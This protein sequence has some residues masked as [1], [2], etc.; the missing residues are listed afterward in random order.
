MRRV[1]AGA[2]EGDPKNVL[3]PLVLAPKPAPKLKLEQFAALEK[4]GQISLT[5]EAQRALKN[6]ADGWIAHDRALHSPR[7]AEFRARLC[8]MIASLEK[9]YAETDLLRA[10]APVLDQHLYHWLMGKDGTSDV[11]GQL[12]ALPTTIEFLRKAKSSLAADSGSARPMDEGRFI[13][14]LADQFE[15]CGCKARAYATSHKADGYAHTPFRAFVHIFYG[16]L[17]LKSRRTRSGLDE[18]MCRA[19]RDRRTGRT[20]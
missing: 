20:R 6:I 16:F 13:Q 7:P 12:A 17:S 18:A 14:F 2:R 15:K 10:D 8:S 4:S 1:K 11:L 9:A 5:T 19:L 3:L